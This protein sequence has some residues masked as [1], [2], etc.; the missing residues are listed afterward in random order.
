MNAR[1]PILIAV[2]LYSPGTGFTRV[3][4]SLFEELKEHA[5]IHWV[6][7]GY[8]GAVIHKG[9]T[10]YPNNINGGDMYGAYFSVD[11]ANKLKAR[12]ILILNDFWML[13]NYQKTFQ[14]LN[15]S[16]SKLAYIPL[17]G[18]IIDPTPIEDVS[19]LDKI[20]LYTEFAAKQTLRAFKNL[21]NI[22]QDMHLPE[23]QVIP[24]GID[25]QYLSLAQSWLLKT[26][27][28][29]P[30]NDQVTPYLF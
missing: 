28:L 21:T 16:I 4:Q 22:N 18:K 17:D 23:V 25:L 6:G 15:P 5:D 1:K 14:N 11:L 12:A 19:F 24:H 10:I 2:G 26:F 27:S 29:R 13:K 8:K 3:L 7:I 30:F 20:V 9:F